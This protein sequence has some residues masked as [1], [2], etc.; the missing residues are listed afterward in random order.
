LPLAALETSWR[1]CL[2]VALHIHKPLLFIFYLI[3]IL[4]NFSVRNIYE[5]P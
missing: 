4:Y 2:S 3:N 5:N 1:V